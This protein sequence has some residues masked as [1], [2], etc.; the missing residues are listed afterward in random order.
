MSERV[1]ITGIGCVSCFGVGHQALIA[2]I[3]SGA[4]GIA[5]ITRFET[6]DC[7]SHR[8]AMIRDFDPTAFFSPLKLRRVDAVGRVV[9]A[10]TRLL[11]D[12]A[13]GAAAS[14]AV[15]GA[16]PL[17]DDV[18]IALGTSTA[19]LDSLSEYLNSLSEHG[20]AGVPAILFSNTVANA[21]ASLCA[22]EF[23]LRGPNVTFNQ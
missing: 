22:I 12:D 6:T 15:A 5:P 19:G 2:A 14:T 23:R 10:C 20:P 4:S 17:G 18:G 1:V 21:P 13:T 7:H 9:L 11:M 3:G 8:A 16:R